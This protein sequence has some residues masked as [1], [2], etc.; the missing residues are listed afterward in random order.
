MCTP[1]L[2]L[3][4]IMLRQI[5]FGVEGAGNVC[6]SLH[7]FFLID[8]RV[9]SEITHRFSSWPSAHQTIENTRNFQVGNNKFDQ[10]SGPASSIFSRK[11]FKHFI[12][13]VFVSMYG[14]S[15]EDDGEDKLLLV[16]FSTLNISQ[17]LQKL[18]EKGRVEKGA[19]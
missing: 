15:F 10:L 7:G 4:D 5:Q 13:S 18:S 19:F 2:L 16:N 9:Y 17:W 12:I 14:D 3:L 6:G 8:R 11:N 1:P